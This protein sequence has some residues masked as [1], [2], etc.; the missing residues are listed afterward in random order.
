MAFAGTPRFEFD[1]PSAGL[2]DRGQA[3]GL[4]FSHVENDGNNAFL[5]RLLG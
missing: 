4:P 1:S 5:I 3:A 2:C